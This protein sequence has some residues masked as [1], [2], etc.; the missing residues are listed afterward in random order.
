MR[1]ISALL[2][3]LGLT[4]TV[5]LSQQLPPPPPPPPSA[6]VMQQPAVQP[7]TSQ[8]QSATPQSAAPQ[9]APAQQAA[10][11]QGAPVQQAPAQE[12][13]APVQQTAPAQ[14]AAPVQ[15]AP[16]Q[17]V[18]QQN[19]STTQPNVPPPDQSGQQVTKT[20][21]TTTK[22]TTE[23]TRGPAGSSDAKN[24][25][26]SDRVSQEDEMNAIREK[27][28][29]RL[30]ESRDVLK[31]LLSGKVPIPNGLLK[32]AKCVVV[33]PSVKKVAFSVGVNYG[34]GVMSCRLG[35]DFN[36]LWSAPS[37]YALEGGSFG[38][39]VGLQGT[40]LV[41]L[42]MNSGGANSLL[43]SKVKLGG[44]MSVA[45]GPIGRS[46]QASTDLAMRAKILAYS[47]AHGVFVGIS[48]EGSTVRPDNRANEALYGREISAK[49]VVRSGEVGVPASAT[50]LIQ[51]LEQSVRVA[52]ESTPNEGHK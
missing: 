25:P 7:D 8:Q 4:T 13:A 22:T 20:T 48:L 24:L 1:R 47:R 27:A 12:Q 21:T 35:E 30:Q 10:P 50:P 3:F 2:L 39:Q 32:K 44:D 36:G 16:A 51:L 18:A 5:A 52:S 33:I 42:V 14:Q 11:Q 28:D 34:R 40:D 26:Q 29:D 43:G 23:V 49:D 9:Q 15:Q 38:F 6:A 41:L 45:A 31:E 37:M 19:P 46:A 17:P